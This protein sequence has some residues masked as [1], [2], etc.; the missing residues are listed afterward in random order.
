MTMA[1]KPIKRSENAFGLLHR[2]A[3]K[4]LTGLERRASQGTQRGLTAIELELR[5][6]STVLDRNFD[7]AKGADVLHSR[8]PSA[9]TG[10][11]FYSSISS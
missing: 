4:M 8:R 7:P 1:P 5:G 11:S 2:G 10:C 9:S 6:V 3:R